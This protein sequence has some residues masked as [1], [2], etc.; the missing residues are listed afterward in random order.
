[1]NRD[2]QIVRMF[3]A[4]GIKPSKSRLEIY[5][6]WADKISYENLTNIIDDV[7]NEEDRLPTISSLNKIN[8]GSAA[9]NQQYIDPE[10]RCMYCEGIGIIPYIKENDGVYIEYQ[11][12]CKCSSGMRYSREIPNYFDIYPNFQFEWDK[13]EFSTYIQV[14]LRERYERIL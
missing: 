8:R 2:D 7:I 11:A 9:S 6:E 4:F 5:L 1:M 14:F 10:N 12:R 13:G 3:G